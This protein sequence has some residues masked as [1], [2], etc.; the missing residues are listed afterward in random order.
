LYGYEVPRSKLR[1]IKSEFAEANSPS[2][3]KLPTSLKLRRDKSP[4]FAPPSSV[5]TEL[6][7]KA[8]HPCSPDESGH[9]ILAKANKKF[10]Q[11]V[12]FFLD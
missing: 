12:H 3:F 7:A 9:G 5:G 11:L 1:G 4:P 10:L 2:L 8:D 6:L